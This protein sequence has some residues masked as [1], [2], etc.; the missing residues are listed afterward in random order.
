MGGQ[1]HAHSI[2]VSSLLPVSFSARFL[3]FF[4]FKSLPALL[5]A[6]LKMYISHRDFMYGLC[7]IGVQDILQPELHRVHIHLPAHHI[8]VVLY[9]QSLLTGTPA[10]K[11]S[12]YGRVGTDHLT[13]KMYVRHTVHFCYFFSNGGGI[14]PGYRE[15]SPCVQC[16][17]HGKPHYGSVFP[18]LA[19]HRS[20]QTVFHHGIHNLLFSC[21][22]QLY[23]CLQHSGRI[24]RQR[25]QQCL[26]SDAKR[27][28]H[29]SFYDPDS[30]VRH[31][32]IFRNRAPDSEH[33]LAA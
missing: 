8:P 19:L 23:I 15:I 11:T 7:L 22:H 20:V 14:S 16:A 29:G 12:V 25:L 31:S 28:S 21:I 13:V 10:P 1:R 33:R 4:P 5:Q 9:K 24:C 26:L 17:G 32:Q 6:F 2:A 27:T 30:G 3:P 18:D